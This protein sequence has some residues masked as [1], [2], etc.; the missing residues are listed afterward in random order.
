MPTK[1]QEREAA[2]ILAMPKDVD[3]IRERRLE[4]KDILNTFLLSKEA[5]AAYEQLY[6]ETGKALERAARTEK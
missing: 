1:E 4:V 3:A 5:R 6:S 2:E